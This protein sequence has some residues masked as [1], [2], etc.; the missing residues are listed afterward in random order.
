MF[1]HPVLGSEWIV[2]GA[3][4]GGM[5]LANESEIRALKGTHW[6]TILPLL[7]EGLE[8]A[9]LARRL[10][11]RVSTRRLSGLLRELSAQGLVHEAFQDMPRAEQAYWSL[12]GVNIRRARSHSADVAVASADK[13]AA[14]E[15]AGALSSLNIKVRAGAPRKI[16]VVSDYLDPALDRWN[17]EAL[18][19]E[20]PWLL[21]R[22]Y[23]R[24]VW[25]GPLFH[26]GKTACWACLERRLRQ[27]GWTRAASVAA[28]PGTVSGALHFAAAQAARW[29]LTGANELLAGAILSFDT[30][31]WRAARRMV[32]RWPQCPAC[33]PLRRRGPRVSGLALDRHVGRVTG[34]VTAVEVAEIADRLFVARGALARVL[35]KDRSGSLSLNRRMPVAGQGSSASAARASCIGEAVERY[36]LMYHGD[37]PLLSASEVGLRRNF[38]SLSRLLCFSENQVKSRASWNRRHGGFHRVPEPLEPAAPIE[39]MSARSLMTSR[40]SLVPAAYCLLGYGASYCIADA[41]GCAAGPDSASATLNALLELI[42][43]DSVA[44]WWYNR[45]RLPRV[46]APDVEA[47]FGSAF[48]QRVLKLID[49]TS[50]IRVPV[51]AAV[52]AGRNGGSTVIGAAAH[53]DLH[54]AARKAAAEASMLSLSLPV[55]RP[56]PAPSTPEERALRRWWRSASLD[57]QAYLVPLRQAHVATPASRPETA[58][59]LLDR[60]LRRLEKCGLDAHWLDHTRPEVGVPVVRTIVP[61]LRHPWARFG[62]G[63]LYDAPVRLGWRRR[64][65]SESQLNPYLFP[66]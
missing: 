64:P 24:E 55:R 43:R 62:P 34:L 61:G 3:M 7:A 17:S 63:R 35:H 12:L 31:S 60:C 50:D 28:L 16:A 25:I 54:E 22:P 9:E 45:V 10:Q 39:W 13:T 44:I 51:V 66:W 19:R 40:R 33:G 37:E 15:L 14:L 30:G 36:S 29:I 5:L 4:P 65:L 52:S 20:T 32:A 8:F 21:V 1:T 57:N 48:P 56:R 58:A 26:P 47:A 6:A 11:G 18:R 38:H 59:T 23:G 27:N 41:N 49:I 46:S 42:E 53:P 2:A